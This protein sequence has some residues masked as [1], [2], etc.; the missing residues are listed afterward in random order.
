MTE[1]VANW[2]YRPENDRIA[3]QALGLILAG[4]L[5]LLYVGLRLTPSKIGA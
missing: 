2:L 1:M 4:A 5:I 3:A